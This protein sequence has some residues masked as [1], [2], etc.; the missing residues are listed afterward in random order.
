MVCR[1]SWK[2]LLSLALMLS[3]SLFSGCFAPANDPAKPVT[4]ETESAPA[5]DASK[6][7]TKKPEAQDKPLE[8]YDPPPLD[9]LNAEAKW[10]SQPVLDAFD[11]LREKQ[12]KEPL[13]ATV[14]EALQLK[15]DSAEANEKILNT[16]G[17]L[18]G[19]DDE[20]DWNATF[21]RHFPSDIRST[22]PVMF[23]LAV[24][25]DVHMLI[26][27][28]LFTIDWNLNQFA[29][30]EHVVSWETSAD[31]MVDKVVMRKDLTWS[32]GKPI[33]AHD[34]AF[35]FQVIMN[36]KV[37]AVAVKSGTDQIRWVHAYDDHTV[38][39]FHKAALATNLGNIEFPIIP[40]H[41]YEKSVESDPTLRD[42]DYH[43]K[44]ENDPVC[45][46]PYTVSKRIRGQEIVLERRESYYMHE[47]KQV[48]PKPYFKTVR[49]NI[50]EDKNTA[51]LALK[52]GDLDEMMLTPD[53]W[54][55]KT[56][57][58]DF[59]AKN[60][61]ATGVDWTEFHFIWNMKTPYFSDVRVRK[62]MSY[63]YNYDEMD[64]VFNQGL[65]QRSN[66][67]FHPTSWM[68]PQAPPDLY[69]QNLDK[70]AELLAEAGWA[71]SDG[72]GVLD[73]EIDGVR[74]KFEF[75][76]MCPS[77]P[78]R[79]KY[80]T[81]L[82]ECLDKLGI[83]CNVKALEFVTLTE[84]VQKR[85]FE[86]A[87]GGWGAGSD[88]DTTVNIFGTG[89]MR[90]YAGFS[91][92]KVDELFKAGKREFDRKKRGEIYGQIHTLIYEQQPYTW[93]Y[94]RNSFYAFGKDLRGYLFSP[95]DPYGY[96]PGLLSIWK[97][98]K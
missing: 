45:G 5:T 42:S 95:R 33:T 85:D 50:I 46:G 77:M 74:V 24:D 30:K 80:C 73:K 67:M 37:P 7:E 3:C 52:K 72:D 32:D 22:N 40:K 97:P 75:S 9:K 89:E 71:D 27:F 25:F 1:S 86:A 34:I 76:I 14:A 35:S 17:K 58:D 12:A 31:R 39:F 23:S 91:D 65:Y 26:A 88:P 78:D 53:D 11:L 19:N 79:I 4:S 47:G 13:T 18:P 20:V 54:T 69:R 2:W 61:K 49:C 62:A 10:I 93:L 43:V 44:Y 16:L 51:L 36:P 66:G 82:K 28:R 15:N 38:V 55:S 60:T 41:I 6:D 94:Y 21:N 83:V 84:R 96:S 64:K 68:A 81:L 48:R 59:Y 70:A 56:V 63:A 90:N 57:G 8:P 87:Y 98:K 29:K 92:P